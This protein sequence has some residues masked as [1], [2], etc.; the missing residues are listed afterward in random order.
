MYCWSWRSGRFQLLALDEAIKLKE[1]RVADKSKEAMK[2]FVKEISEKISCDL[3]TTE[4]V[5]EAAKDAIIIV[6]ATTADGVIVKRDWIKDGCL[7]V[8]IESYQ[9]LDY[10]STKSMDK[11]VVDHLEQMLHR[12][13]LAKWVARG[14]ISERDVYAELGDIV[15]GKKK[16][17]VSDEE[18]I[19]CVP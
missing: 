16:G 7:V 19:L 17:R 11:I 5:E 14:L 1:A 12:G 9:E 8:S 6:T 4:N 2:K 10:A 13:E 18:R 3:T 15:A